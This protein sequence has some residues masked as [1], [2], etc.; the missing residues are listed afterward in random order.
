[1][2]RS[3]KPLLFALTLSLVYFSGTSR[4][5]ADPLTLTLDQQ[6]FTVTPGARVSF[7][8][9]L[10]NSS[11]NSYTFQVPGLTSDGGPT[12]AFWVFGG[13]GTTPDPTMPTFI[14][15]LSSGSG[16]LFD[17]FIKP[18]ADLGTYSGAVFIRGFLSGHFN[19]PLYEVRVQAPFV[20]SVA[21]AEVPEPASLM[22]LGTGLV[23]LTGI[24]RR[25]KQRRSALEGP[26]NYQGE[27]NASFRQ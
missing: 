14:D 8:G 3:V 2:F 26:G 9:T 11:T 19:D 23:G 6:Q 22:L 27:E 21:P 13:W 20:L 17:I 24:Y 15:S 1:M 7:S 10:T 4:A 5:E 18:D 25:R 16:N 12:G